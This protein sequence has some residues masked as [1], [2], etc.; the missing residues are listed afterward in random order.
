MPILSRFIVLVS[1]C[2][3]CFHTCLFADEKKEANPLEEYFRSCQ[4]HL[5]QPMGEQMCDTMLRMAQEANDTRMEVNAAWLKVD[6]YYF[7]GDEKNI[8]RQAEFAKKLSRANDNLKAYYFI[9]GNRLISFYIINNQMN[10]ALYEVNKMLQEAQQDDYKPGIAECF[11]SFAVIYLSQSAYELAVEYYQKEI[12]VYE[13]EGIKNH[14]LPVEYS[15][16]AQCA[17]E[18]NRVDRAKEAIEKGKS[19]LDGTDLYQNFVIHKAS[20]FLYLHQGEFDKAHKELQQMERLIADNEGMRQYIDGL[21]D[22][23]LRYYRKTKQHDKALAVIEQLLQEEPYRSTVYLR[24]S[25]TKEKGEIYRETGRFAEATQ[26]YKEFIEANDTLTNQSMQNAISEFNTI[27]EVELLQKEKDSL[28]L[29]VQ[30]KKLYVTY[31]IIASLLAV[32]MIGWVLYIRIYRLNGRLKSS[33]AELR[34]AKE[35]AEQVSSM[36]SEFI[37]NMSHEIRTPLNSIVGFSQ[38]LSEINDK[39]EMKEYTDIISKNSSDL[40]RLVNDVLNLSL[41]DKED[42]IAYDTPDDINNSCQNS[43]AVVLPEVKPG[44]ELLFT[45]SCHDL[46]INT[47]PSLVTQVLTQLLHNAVK[48]TTQGKIILSYEIIDKQIVYSVTDTGIGIPEDKQEYIF[49][50]FAKLDSFSQG[51]GL[52]LSLCRLI[53]GRLGGSLVIDKTYTAGCRFL[54]TLPYL[55]FA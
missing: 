47:N 13:K 22:A 42:N 8:V 54:L 20:L 50:R 16:L 15:T 55:V 52:G 14:N 12:D 34:T 30:R 19:Y 17:I 7:N 37:Q 39:P 36:K 31:L 6:Y 45:P 41:I 46:I 40:L 24:N 23:R 29:D 32:W 4:E 3:L 2:I 26:A 38:I 9:W 1:I 33:E 5:Y 11:R 49:E 27:L 21:H 28:L 43:M 18:L 48:F 44:V 10:I 53:A 51:T 25:L 35:K